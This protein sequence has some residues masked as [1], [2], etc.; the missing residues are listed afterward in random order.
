MQES[1]A[2]DWG[3]VQLLLLTTAR[4][5]SLIGARDRS[6]STAPVP[7]ESCGK[8]TASE[9]IRRDPY[10]RLRQAMADGAFNNREQIFRDGTMSTPVPPVL[11]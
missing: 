9:S 8:G 7:S 2:T 4:P 3:R 11:A 6:I 10:R 1:A 5:K